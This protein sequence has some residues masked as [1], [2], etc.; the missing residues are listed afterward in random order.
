[1]SKLFE[2]TEIKTLALPNRLVR[3][4]TWEGMADEDGG[5]T[6]RLI[7]TMKTL[8]GGGVGLII[9]GHAFVSPEGQASPWQ[10]GIHRDDLVPGLRELTGAVHG[11]G[12]RIVLQLAHA[13]N[14]AAEDLT[15][16]PPLVV[17]DFEGL[18]E[19]P[20]KEMTSEDIEG[21]VRAFADAASRARS[22]G[23]DGVQ[24]HS[25]HGYLLS[26]FL[27]PFFNR[28]RDGYGGSVRNRARIHLETCRAI[29]EAVGGDYPVLIKLNCRDFVE[30]GLSLEDSLEVAAL[31]AADGGIDA[32]E[33]SGGVI[34][35]G[36][37]SPSRR[38]IGSVEKEAYF[39]EYAPAFKERVPL[40]LILV[41]GIR[42][43][44]VAEGLLRD[45][46]VD[47]V[48]MSR[49]LICEPDLP[50]RWKAGDRR[51]SECRSDNLC[52][53]PGLNG[54]GVH[55]VVKARKRSKSAGG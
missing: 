20:R 9:S 33:L 31:L 46:T 14:F 2:A 28:R 22:A 30:G 55:C 27:S 1:M 11:E 21:I 13:G 4:A 32:V 45:G 7:E 5:V 36:R 35:G 23:F 52:F 15:G 6:P 12:G 38:G 41:G 18:A 50:Q 39:R 54:E 44:E 40:P 51:K 37:L 53:R 48:S 10:L 34:H 8:A 3:S 25:A 29:R 47:L 26:Q 43:F 42:T 17:S 24:I 49:P 19:R 16:Q